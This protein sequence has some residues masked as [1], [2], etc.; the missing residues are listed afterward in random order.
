[1]RSECHCI[2][3]FSSHI[4]KLLSKWWWRYF[5]ILFFSSLGPVVAVLHIFKHLSLSTVFS[6]WELFLLFTFPFD[7]TCQFIFIF[8]SHDF[9]TYPFPFYNVSD[10]P[11]MHL[12]IWLRLLL[13]FKMMLILIPYPTRMPPPFQLQSW[14]KIF[15]D[16]FFWVVIITHYPGQMLSLN[17]GNIILIF[18]IT[19]NI[20]YIYIY[21]YICIVDIYPSV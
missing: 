15:M 19:C 9:D 5:L 11:C 3:S 6:S 8:I 2:S 16:R 20:W 18:S 14:W 4:Y 12:F 21:I 1:M 13:K 17:W 7:C 10:P